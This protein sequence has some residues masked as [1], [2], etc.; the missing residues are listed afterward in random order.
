MKILTTLFITLLLPLFT[1]AQGVE[2]EDTCSH[3]H[4]IDIS[5]YQGNIFWETVANNTSMAYV[6]ISRN[7]MPA[8]LAI[9][10]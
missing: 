5:H 7:A 3:V 10:S 4:G 8:I 2:C 9:I 1:F 6:Y